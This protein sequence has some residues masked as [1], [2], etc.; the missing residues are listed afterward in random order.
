MVSPRSTMLCRK[1]H[2]SQL[3]KIIKFEFVA[4][5]HLIL[6]HTDIFCFPSFCQMECGQVNEGF[7][8]S[9]FEHLV[10]F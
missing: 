1:T 8:Y 9:E 2:V 5:S 6:L 4:R 10:D 7:E 3:L